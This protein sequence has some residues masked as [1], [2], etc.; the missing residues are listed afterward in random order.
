MIRIVMLQDPTPA[1]PVLRELRGAIDEQTFL[2]RLQAAREAGYCMM[3]AYEAENIVGV[4]GYRIV[5]DICWGQTFYIDDLVVAAQGRGH[6]VGGALLERGRNTARQMGCDHIRL[7][8]G[9]SRADAHR[10]YEA[11]GMTGLSKQFVF[12]LNGGQ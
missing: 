2:T 12:T 4:L 11:H 10:F 9:L 8:S 7:C 5:H 6:G 3:A 1:L